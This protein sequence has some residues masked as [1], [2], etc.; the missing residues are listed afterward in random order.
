[1]TANQQTAEA[2]AVRGAARA[3]CPTCERKGRRVERMTLESLLR[4]VRR[5]AIGVGQY[6]VCAASDC[7]TVYFGP[8]DAPVFGKSDLTVRFGLKESSG[9]RPICY[10]FEHTVES[11]H[12]EIARSGRSTV[13]E[14]IRADMEQVGCRCERTNPLGGC[15]LASVRQVVRDGMTEIG[16]FDP[17]LATERNVE[18]CAPQNEPP[19]ALVAQVHRGRTGVLATA[20]SSCAAVL[21]SA[22]CWLPLLLLT[23]GLSAGGVASFFEA[24]RWPLVALAG[25]LL[26]IGFYTAYRPSQSADGQCCSGSPRRRRWQRGML[27]VAAAFVGAMVLFPNYVQRLI[28]SP[29]V[30]ALARTDDTTT[31]LIV[32]VKGMTC[33][34][35]AATLTKG[36][37][38]VPGVS[39]VDVVYSDK[40]ARVSVMRDDETIRRLITQAV[41]ASGFTT[42]ADAIR[43]AER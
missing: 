1:M 42:E 23:F 21:S 29:S 16:S 40:I 2:K 20:G 11:I 24:W 31:A 25:V 37:G 15:C 12:D 39:A 26:G 4:D 19:V 30:P 6:Y 36:L 7:D 5:G 18:C 43:A 28:A 27:W 17:S 13:L 35:C 41:Q 8:V 10:C 14:R 3:L 32:P 9:P 34:G 22:C 38:D 33:E